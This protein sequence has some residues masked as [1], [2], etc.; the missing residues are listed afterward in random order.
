MRFFTVFVLLIV[1][2]VVFCGAVEASDIHSLIRQGKLEEARSALDRLSRDSSRTGNNQ[3]FRALL[4]PDGRR[5]AELLESASQRSPDENYRDEIVLR[6]AQYYAI[7][8][9]YKNIG[10]VVDARKT[11]GLQATRLRVLTE[12][13]SGAPDAARTRTDGLLK[14]SGSAEQKQWVSI[15]QARQLLAS[16]KRSTARI[17]LQVLLKSK[18]SPVQ[19]QALYLLCVDAIESGKIDDAAR[20]YNLLKEQYPG[21]VG[22]DALVDKL[23]SMPSQPESD[24]RAEKVTGTFYSVKVGVFSSP[25][26]AEQQ[27]VRFR[28]LKFTVESARKTVG[29][30]K[31]IIVYIGRYSSFDDADQVKRE[32]ESKTGEQ[33]QVVAR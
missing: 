7:R 11:S 26:N 30:K 25:E 6:L 29:G 9:E 4:E 17:N 23:G 33:Y 14:S 22:L 15:D 1:H 27:V 28:S 32:L 10:A 24:T 19:A 31:Y 5:S 8:G 2:S 21:A 16:K 12:E 18:N 3:Y 13:Q 20:W